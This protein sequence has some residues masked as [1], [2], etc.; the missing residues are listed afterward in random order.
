M[1]R[2]LPPSSPPAAF[3]VGRWFAD[4]AADTLTLDGRTVKLEP[5]AMRLLAALA[6]RPSE[7]H[8][9]GELL[10]SVWRGVV[11][12]DQSLYQA[13]G[14]LRAALKADTSTREFIVNVPRKGYRLVAPVGPIRA[15][16]PVPIPSLAARTIAVLPLR[17]LGLTPEFSFLRETLLAELVLELSRQPGL[18]T[19]ARGTMLSYATRAV[20]ARQVAEELKVGYVV[21][22][23]IAKAGD[24]MTIACEL[25]DAASDTVLVSESIRVSAA[26][27][28]ALA[29]RVVGR[30]AR[31]LRFEFSAHATRAVDAAG[32]AHTGALELAMRAWVELYA[33]PQNRETNERAW[34]W[35]TEALSKDESIGA[36]WNALGYC[37][38][39]AAQ[40][41][42]HE[43]RSRAELLRD[44]VAHSQ[45]AI[46]LS[47]SDPDAYYTFGLSTYTSGETAQAEASL[48]HCTQISASYAPAWGL[49]G[50]VRAVQGH[51][52]ETAA[53]C[54]RAFAL[55]PREPLRAV[56]L[57][58]EACAA[59]ML[60]DDARALDRASAGIAANPDYP[61]CYLVAAVSALRLGRDDAAARYTTVLRT[62]AFSSVAKLRES[63][64]TMR[65]EPWASAFLADLQRAGLPAR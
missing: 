20:T 62:S 10:E 48:R 53:L 17:D 22:G 40:Y 44:A 58:S 61:A 27:W 5:R 51:P 38:W 31:A 60:G 23:S 28:R 19:I 42:W 9:S 11:V 46:S 54:E 3:S 29:S 16:E 18:A 26:Q 64:P 14:E 2:D 36:A 8:G 65:V 37:E 57:W 43:S 15:A 45:R 39:R 49:L 7:V 1:S 47:P 21:D 55:S 41:G 34:A 32:P 13:I 50:L 6:R 25:I 59:S 35:A 4:P 56:W 24:E 33:R 52:A 63:L 12:T 30:L